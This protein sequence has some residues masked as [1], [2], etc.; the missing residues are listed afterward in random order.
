MKM[1]FD[2]L[3]FSGTVQKQKFVDTLFLRYQQRLMH[4]DLLKRLFAASNLP[5]SVPFLF[6]LYFASTRTMK[7]EIA[8]PSANHRS[9]H[10]PLADRKSSLRCCLHRERRFNQ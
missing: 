1:T 5:S 2:C 10:H 7:V 4:V 3:I 8:S 9:I 6:S